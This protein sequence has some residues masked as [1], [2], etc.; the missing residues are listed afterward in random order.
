MKKIIQALLIGL[1]LFSSTAL[2]SQP[3]FVKSLGQN[4][5]REE[6]YSVNAINGGGVIIGGYTQNS[7]G[8]GRDALAIVLDADGN[9]IWSK[10]Y[11][12]Q[13]NETIF[14]IKPKSIGGYIA[15]GSIADANSGSF[16]SSRAVLI[17][18][19]S[20]AG[21][22]EWSKIYDTLN[23]D[24]FGLRV[25]E[26][27]QNH[28]IVS[29]RYAVDNQN[30][31]GLTLDIDGTG[32][33]LGHRYIRHKPTSGTTNTYFG[34][35]IA[36]NDDF[37]IS[38]FASKNS[39]DN[40]P[41]AIKIARTSNTAN[42]SSS[43]I[44]TTAR[45]E[46]T[47]GDQGSY[48]IC[49]T[50]EAGSGFFTAGNYWY[51]ISP[52]KEL[53][54]YFMTLN[55]NLSRNVM[56]LYKDASTTRHDVR[57][58]IVKPF[59][60]KNSQMYI[61]PISDETPGGK[62]KAGMALV[63]ED[64]TLSWSSF[65]TFPNKDAYSSDACRTT[66]GGFVTVGFT[67]A[68]ST[69]SSV[70]NILVIKVNAKGEVTSKS[71]SCINIESGILTPVDSTFTTVT[72][73]TDLQTGIHPVTPNPSIKDYAFKDTNCIVSSTVCG[74]EDV[75]NLINNGD[76]ENGTTD[77]TSK[78]TQ[79]T[80]TLVPGTY[81]V[82]DYASYKNF[83]SNWNVSNPASCPRTGA[84]QGKFLVINGQTG[85]Q[86]IKTAWGQSVT[87][88][89]GKD[90]KLCMNLKN[91]AQC[92]FDV[93]PS[94]S[95]LYNDGTQQKTIGPI[96]INQANN[97]CDWNKYTTT[98][99]IPASSSP[100][101]NLPINI[102]L[103]QSGLGDGNDLAIDD[104]SL[105]QLKPMAASVTDFG[106]DMSPIDANGKYTITATASALPPGAGFYWE[107]QDIT[108]PSHPVILSNPAQWWSTPLS[109]NFN[110]YDN[111]IIVNP[112][113]PGIF[114]ANRTYR[115]VRGTWGECNSWS[116]V[117]HIYRKEINSNRIAVQKDNKYNAPAPKNTRSSEN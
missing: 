107:I 86:G 47:T 84:M 65:Y 93:K 89:T 108:D 10:T 8:T 60:I 82:A 80:T 31:Y 2:F 62:R 83:C 1:A 13:K 85:Q 105:I 14:C 36:G 90:Y 52:S 116:A 99:S 22:L 113:I 26:V 106:D 59:V 69:S 21:A 56:K 91:L 18:S 64:C 25:L 49:R 5:T 109:T 50:S 103:D 12:F 81:T 29:G 112:S 63:K 54:I 58:N 70:G 117:S 17:L 30:S 40:D 73:N 35:V 101:I 43:A 67:D 98:I 79:M 114:V 23:V 76:F 97:A 72:F 45:Y 28:F 20:S 44:Q 15:V 77:F 111:G 78:F 16:I 61:S 104:I 51:A 95:I 41:I 39:S 3:T 46:Q 74:C 9:K 94:V 115:I 38:G 87:V 88:E 100:T 110:G 53:G 33:L 92:C 24:D 6:A 71:K 57:T 7:S 19:I 96:I 55:N 37:I 75:T 4:N 42:I 48:T 68:F 66:D 11:D 102:A 27:D 32:A 34:D